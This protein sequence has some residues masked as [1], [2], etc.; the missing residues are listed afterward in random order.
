MSDTDN[1]GLTSQKQS[2]HQENH[3][4]VAQSVSENLPDSEPADP[5]V[6]VI[7]HEERRDTRLVHSG[8]DT[9]NLPKPLVECGCGECSDAVDPLAEDT[10][11]FRDFRYAKDECPE[12]EPMTVRRAAEAYIRYQKAADNDP[13]K[14]SL[15]EVT[16]NHYGNLLGAERELFDRM[17][18]PT[19]I[20]LSLRVSPIARQN[21]K[22]RWIH[23]VTLDQRLADSWENVRGVLNY[24]LKEYDTEYVWL[25]ATTDSAGT[26]HRH[27][28]IYAD[29]PDDGVSINVPRA[30]V[31]SFVN[32][33]QGAEASDHPVEAGNSDAGMLF[34][35]P[36][37]AEEALINRNYQEHG[38]PFWVP[39]VPLYYIANQ[40]PH[41]CLKNVYDPTHPMNADSVQVDGGAI[42]F[43]STNNWLGSSR[44]FPM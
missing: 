16:R 31:D 14:T 38:G 32:N 44:G 29:D 37:K 21:G 43:A 11:A 26:P 39:T 7:D 25:T 6:D 42:A 27:V 15:L 8:F 12:A 13:A 9:D 5:D 10:F 2:N 34:H 19:L 22:R 20:F 17:N 40:L 41:W 23:P 24:R 36:P 35:D 18:D 1:Y 30:A 4:Q 28:L 3:Q 33:T